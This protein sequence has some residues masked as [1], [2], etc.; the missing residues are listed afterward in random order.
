MNKTSKSALNAIRKYQKK[1]VF[2]GMRFI[3]GKDDD[4]I[5][6][7]AECDSKIDFLRTA[8]RNLM[9]AKQPKRK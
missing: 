7:L 5:E 2:I 4:I 6:F 8:I 1:T 3:V 9:P